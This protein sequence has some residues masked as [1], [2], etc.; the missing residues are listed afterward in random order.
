MVR[1]RHVHVLGSIFNDATA[2]GLHSRTTCVRPRA[3]LCVPVWL[4]EHNQGRP[5][6]PCLKCGKEDPIR[7]L[8]YEHLRMNGWTARETRPPNKGSNCVDKACPHA[9]SAC[10][11]QLAKLRRQECLWL[12]PNHTT[13]MGGDI[14][15]E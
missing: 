9:Q 12:G 7:R 2:P 5:T 13:V 15:V 3:P 6:R 1:P 8:R 11:S 10:H 4:G 14:H